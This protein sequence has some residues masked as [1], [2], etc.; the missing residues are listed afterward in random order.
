MNLLKY[1]EVK[2]KIR[3][4][5]R[6]WSDGTALYFNWTCSGFEFKFRGSFLAARFYAEGIMEPDGTPQQ[7]NLT[8]HP[9]WPWFGVVIDGEDQPS[10]R[11]MC[12]GDCTEVL[13]SS[14]QPETHTIRI[15]KLT[16]NLKTFLSLESFVTDGELEP[17]K[18]PERAIEFIGDSITCGFGNETREKDRFYFSEDENGWLSHGAIAAR[19]LDMEWNMISISGICIA[20]RK[21][22]PMEY[23]TNQLYCHTDRPGQEKADRVAEEWDFAANPKDYVVLNLGTND[24]NAIS[25]DEDPEALEA[26]FYED[27]ISFLKTLRRCNSE[28]TWLIC[29]MG[30]M[31]YY[32][33][34][35]ILKAVEDYRRQTGDQRI[36]CMKYMRISPMD[37]LGAMGHPFVITQ[38]KMADSL[39]RHI[40]ALEAQG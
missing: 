39:V 10:R 2:D 8:A 6:T 20:P 18:A 25:M 26:Q 38:Q 32:L 21:T 11:V 19:A 9:V 40:R 4:I 17:T 14:S 30:S 13:F 22:L 5:G 34:D 3:S 7:T 28:K 1:S 27:Y 16:E 35:T 12:V 15:V 36:S 29:A 23:A 37:P 31:D 33:Y 24:A